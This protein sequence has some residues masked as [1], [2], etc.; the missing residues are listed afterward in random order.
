MSRRHFLR[1]DESKLPIE[2]FDS[3]EFEEKDLS[4]QE[5]LATARRA[6]SSGSL[7]LSR[8]RFDIPL[9]CWSKKR[10]RKTHK[11]TRG[12]FSFA[13]VVRTKRRANKETRAFFFEQKKPRDTE[14]LSRK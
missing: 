11:N 9:F 10:R 7:S 12:L 14:R 6:E 5:W 2:T 3:L 8:A 13:R 1:L 4:P